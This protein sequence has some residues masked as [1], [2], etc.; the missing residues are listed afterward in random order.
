MTEPLPD[1]L[2]WRFVRQ[3]TVPEVGLRGQRLLLRSRLAPCPAD[4]AP[5]ALETA[6]LYLLR[7]GVRDAAPDTEDEAFFELD[8]MHLPLPRLEEAE[9]WSGGTD[10]ARVALAAMLA[11]ALSATS[12]M[13]R[14]LGLPNP[15]RPWEETECPLRSQE[16]A[17]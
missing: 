15:E 10:P 14:R 6:R 8:P 12:A 9:R 13:A 1:P 16:E 5:L 2:A 7:A 3:R 4:P 17:R 11:G